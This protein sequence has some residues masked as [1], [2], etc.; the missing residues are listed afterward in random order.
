MVFSRCEDTAKDQNTSDQLAWIAGNG[1]PMY[2]VYILTHGNSKGEARE[3]R[4][5][6]N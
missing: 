3:S 5:K 1:D 6:N 4:H 2:E